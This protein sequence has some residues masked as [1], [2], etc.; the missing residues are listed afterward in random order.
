MLHIICTDHGGRTGGGVLVL[1]GRS[2]PGANCIGRQSFTDEG[3]QVTGRSQDRAGS[4]E[5]WTH[6]QSTWVGSR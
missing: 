2:Q 5:I 3:S 1:P 4:P 6:D